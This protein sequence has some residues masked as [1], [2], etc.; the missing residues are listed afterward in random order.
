[1]QSASMYTNSLSSMSTTNDWVAP[2][3]SHVSRMEFDVLTDG[4]D[5]IVLAP[6]KRSGIEI[7]FTY[8]LTLQGADNARRER[9]KLFGEFG[10]TRYTYICTTEDASSM[11]EVSRMLIDGLQE[12]HATMLAD[13]L[14]SALHQTSD[15]DLRSFHNAIAPACD[16]MTP[17]LVRCMERP[18]PKR[19]AQLAVRDRHERFPDAALTGHFVFHG[20]RL[21]K[22][23]TGANGRGDPCLYANVLFTPVWTWE[24]ATVTPAASTS[25]SVRRIAIRVSDARPGPAAS[26][27]SC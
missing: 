11:R 6:S 13:A 18:R 25:M 21:S 5:A 22:G 23:T 1:M 19:F 24:R 3:R 8:D 26:E 7:A 14:Q 17:Q 4:A 2:F 10:G 12:H 15:I 16:S 9:N 27:S 20:I